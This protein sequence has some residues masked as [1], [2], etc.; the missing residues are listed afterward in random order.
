MRVERETI[1]HPA[2]SFRLLR[3][4]QQAFTNARHRHAHLEL[5]WI[6]AGEGLRFVGNHVAPFEAGDL[7]LIGPQLPHTWVSTP[8]HAGRRHAATVLQIAPEL[9]FHS[10]LPEL[11]ALS[12]LVARAGRG[13]RIT[14][15]AHAAVTGALRELDAAG[16]DLAQLA[17]VIRLLGLLAEHEDD[18]AALGTLDEREA[19]MGERRIDRV[20][21]W[22]DS[23]YSE[24]LCVEEAARLV[25]VS[26]AAFSR[27]FR[28]EVGKR[29]SEYVNDVR[30]S[31]ACLLLA[32][33]E[34][35]VAAVAQACGFETLSNFSRQFQRRHGMTP[36]AFRKARRLG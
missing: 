13:L 28:R 4:T 10:A 30:C 3:L 2:R 16:S 18:M 1:S 20:L 21:A 6:E 9:L 23:R 36:G 34:R 19:G 31:E 26:P 25:H 35:G 14:G 8:A 15:A 12:G 29:F 11:A 7:V 5:T 22:I 17:L 27:Y 24:A 33:G 32:R